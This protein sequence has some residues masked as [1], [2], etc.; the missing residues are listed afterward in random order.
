MDGARAG[1]ERSSEES[2]EAPDRDRESGGAVERGGLS[3]R[4]GDA[5]EEGTGTRHGVEERDERPGAE[6]GA[7]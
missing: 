4:H 3:K 7:G 2:R 6:D 5:L 1:L